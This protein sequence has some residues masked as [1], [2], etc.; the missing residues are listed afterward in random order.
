MFHVEIKTKAT[1]HLLSKCSQSKHFFVLLAT[2]WCV[3]RSHSSPTIMLDFQDLLLPADGRG[4]RQES[5]V[6]PLLSAGK[7]TLLHVGAASKED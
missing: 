2:L 4:S 7:G 1:T 6:S 3:C 5:P